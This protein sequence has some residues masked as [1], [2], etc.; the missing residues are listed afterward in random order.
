[1][2]DEQLVPSRQIAAATAG[3]VSFGAVALQAAASV[4]SRLLVTDLPQRH[5]RIVLQRAFE[6]GDLERAWARR[7]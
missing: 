5:H 1:M 6:L 7:P 2:C 4:P 3:C